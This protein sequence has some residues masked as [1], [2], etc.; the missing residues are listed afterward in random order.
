MAIFPAK[1]KRKAS[2]RSRYANQRHARTSQDT[3]SNPVYGVSSGGTFVLRAASE[4]EHEADYGPVRIGAASSEDEDSHYPMDHDDSEMPYSFDPEPPVFAISQHSADRLTQ[5]KR[6]MDVVIP[7]LV[8]IYLRVL[9]ESKQLRDFSQVT[10]RMC[11]E[12]CTQKMFE[13]QCVSLDGKF[14][15]SLRL[16]NI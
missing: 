8:P 11:S 15:Y 4:D 3:Q 14:Y 9:R 5:A 10:R 2:R 16:P 6:W 13:V 1:T 7:K 12:R